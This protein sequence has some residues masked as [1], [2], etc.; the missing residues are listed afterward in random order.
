MAGDIKSRHDFYKKYKIFK[1]I[2]TKI[3]LEK[4][5]KMHI[6]LKYLKIKL[7]IYIRI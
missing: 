5:N 4:V 2:Q 3:T 7:L 1:Q 6:N